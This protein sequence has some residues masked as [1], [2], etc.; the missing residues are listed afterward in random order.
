MSEKHHQGRSDDNPPH[1]SPDDKETIFLWNFCN[2]ADFCTKPAVESRINITHESPWK[3][4][5]SQNYISKLLP[6]PI[7]K[8]KVYL[9]GGGGGG[10]GKAAE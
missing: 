2:T 4:K 3:F 5:S 10:G 8:K 1:F 6:L 7:K 9:N